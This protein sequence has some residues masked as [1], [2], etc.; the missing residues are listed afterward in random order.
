MRRPVVVFLG[1][2]AFFGLAVSPAGAAPGPDGHRSCASGEAMGP[3]ESP[4]AVSVQVPVDCL[5]P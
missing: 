4:I 3:V 1:I 2:L 5:T